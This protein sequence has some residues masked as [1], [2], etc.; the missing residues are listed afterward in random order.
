MTHP[1]I[2][3]AAGQ[4]TRF[5]DCLPRRPKPTYIVPGL[6]R[7]LIGDTILKL[8]ETRQ[9][10]EVVVVT[11]HMAGTL[12]EITRA[13]LRDSEL[14][15]PV[16]FAS[17]EPDYL[18]GPLYSFL[19]GVNA[20]SARSC[21]VCP[22]DT[23]FSISQL[24]RFTTE[25]A[26]ESAPVLLTFREH[27][28][29]IP[30]SWAGLVTGDREISRLFPTRHLPKHLPGGRKGQREFQE[31]WIGPL[32]KVPATLARWIQE[33]PDPTERTLI[34]ALA[35]YL[36]RGHS[37]RALEVNPGR[38]IDFDDKGQVHLWETLVRQAGPALAAFQ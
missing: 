11:G 14:A 9:V 6:N 30:G 38:W 28:F 12:E 24:T 34:E 32:L 19:H 29:G 33:N 16:R 15:L 4:G 35:R 3:L 37:C 18:D 25:A 7:P 26:Q 36:S 23:L 5:R 17:A 1:A 27:Q 22:G 13:F 31:A 20:V 2:L 21:F 8:A 10:S